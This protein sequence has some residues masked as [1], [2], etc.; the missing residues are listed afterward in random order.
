EKWREL[1][2]DLLLVGAVDLSY[3]SSATR[4]T[5]P[6]AYD[7]Y[8][9]RSA[10]LGLALRGTLD[11]AQKRA[12]ASEADADVEAAAATVE[13]AEKGT[14]LLVARAQGA[15]VATLERAKLAQ[16]EKTAARRWLTAVQLGF[17]AGSGEVQ[18]VLAA[19]IAVAYAEAS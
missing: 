12:A 9:S 19:A 13:L 7:P 4:Q 8:N 14:R 11:V 3:T 18:E 16:D 1:L 6:F 15:A 10:G 2:P 17:D 5:N